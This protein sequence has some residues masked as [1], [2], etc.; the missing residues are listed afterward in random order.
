MRENCK[1]SLLVA[2]SISCRRRSHANCC[3]KV[4]NLQLQHQLHSHKRT[5]AH[6]DTHINASRRCRSAAQVVNGNGT[7]ACT[8][9]HTLTLQHTHGYHA[10]SHASLSSPPLH[11]LPLCRL[12]CQSAHICATN[13][14]S[15]CI[16]SHVL[17]LSFDLRLPADWLVMDMDMSLSVLNFILQLHCLPPPC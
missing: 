11:P 2:R 14:A 1:S 3:I 10:A 16:A 17:F 9:A 4:K 13:V 5:H 7:W 6:T 15:H 8:L 12:S